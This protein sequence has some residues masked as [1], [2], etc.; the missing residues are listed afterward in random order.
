MLSFSSLR[1]VSWASSFCFSE[2]WSWFTFKRLVRGISWTFCKKWANP[3]LFSS[4][5][6]NIFT[7]N[8][9]EKCPSSIRQWDSNSQPSSDYEFP[10]LTTR[11]G[12]PVLY[13]KLFFLQTLYNFTTNECEKCPSSIQQWDSNSQPSSD[14][15]FPRLTTRP[16]LPVL[17]LK[18][19]FLQRFY[20]F[21][22]NE[23]EKCPSSIRRWDSNSQPSS[24]YEF[25]PLTTRPG[26]SPY[27]LNFFV[28]LSFF[29]FPVPKCLFH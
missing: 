4:F 16:G 17:Y 26:L 18:L 25:P 14:Y 5:L 8:E 22:T 9:C 15:E 27:I 11:P 13:L 21:T 1:F 2:S 19:F 24:D 6:T 12:L 20:N 3:G 29:V 23:C 7:T 10:P 28:E